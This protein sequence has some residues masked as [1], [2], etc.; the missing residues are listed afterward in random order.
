M[1]DYTVV[2]EGAVPDFTLK[3]HRKKANWNV[4]VKLK[5]ELSETGPELKS[6]KEIM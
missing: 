5:L 4:K 1:V 2:W 6:A 3:K